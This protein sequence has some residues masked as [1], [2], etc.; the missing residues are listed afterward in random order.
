MKISFEGIGQRVV[1][2]AKDGA[3]EGRVC[4]LSANDTVKDC[5]AG[6]VFCGVTAHSEEEA[7]AVITSGFVTL[8]Y[9]GSAPSL[10]YAKL[11]ANASGGVAVH[12]SGREYLVLHV[13]TAA[14][15]VGLFL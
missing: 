7:A 10:G 13:D 3:T 6:E 14:K 5:A 11:A 12:A 15:T 8:G 2:F 1:T 9:S 4:K